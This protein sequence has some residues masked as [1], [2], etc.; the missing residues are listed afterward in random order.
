MP[1]MPHIA[2]CTHNTPCFEY[3]CI[4]ANPPAAFAVQIMAGKEQQQNAEAQVPMLS[5]P[6]FVTITL[7]TWFQE[8]EAMF[9][10]TRPALTSG[11]K[12]FHL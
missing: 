7:T 4:L 6:Y 8:A 9:A 1:T 10:A 5:L 12:Y 11:Q 2:P 3:P